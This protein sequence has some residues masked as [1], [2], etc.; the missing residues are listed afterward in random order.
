MAHIK[1]NIFDFFVCHGGQ[2]APFG[3]YL[4]FLLLKFG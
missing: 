3:A 4:Q 2:K 1:I